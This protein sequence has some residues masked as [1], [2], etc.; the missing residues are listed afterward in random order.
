MTVIEI[1]EFMNLMFLYIYKEL[2]EK[3]HIREEWFQHWN[4]RRKPIF[5]LTKTKVQC[6]KQINKDTYIIIKL[7]ELNYNHR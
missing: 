2:R 6:A 1:F 5:Q 4:T 3:V 7:N